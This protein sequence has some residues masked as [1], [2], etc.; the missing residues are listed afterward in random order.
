MNTGVEADM[1][2]DQDSTREQRGDSY[3]PVKSDLP[4]VRQW[5]LRAAKLLETPALQAVAD[6]SQIAVG[7]RVGK[8]EV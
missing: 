6:R 8:D 4:Q 3:F 1:S 7:S 2:T 5:H